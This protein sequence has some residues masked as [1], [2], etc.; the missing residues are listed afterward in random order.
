MTT[1]AAT[2][3][4][5]PIGDMEKRKV[6]EPDNKVDIVMGEFKAGK[7]RSSSGDKVTDPK[8]ALAIALSEQRRENEETPVKLEEKQDDPVSKLLP[9]REAVLRAIVN[10]GQDNFNSMEKD[11]IIEVPDV[12]LFKTGRY[13]GIETTKEDLRNKEKA[14]RELGDKHEPFLKLTHSDRDEHSDNEHLS[15]YPFSVGSI[16][17]NT[18]RVEGDSLGGLVKMFKWVA[19]LIAKGYLRSSS[20]EIKHNVTT[21]DGKFYSRV[22]D[23]LALL[24]SKREAQW[25]TLN[26]YHDSGAVLN[27]EKIIIYEFEENKMP[28]TNSTPTQE[29]LN[30]EEAAPEKE[31]KSENM[32]AE[33]KSENMEMDKMKEYMKDYMEK[34]MSEFMEKYMGKM[35][36]EEEAEEAEADMEKAEMYSE[37]NSDPVAKAKAELKAEYAEK[38]AEAEKR[39]KLLEAERI[40]ERRARVKQED[41][42]FVN[43]LV[44]EGKLAPAFAD[45]AFHLVN[46]ASEEVVAA[47]SE[48]GDDIKKSFKEQVKDFLSSMDKTMTYSE[49]EFAYADGDNDLRVTKDDLELYGG[50][51]KHAMA[52]KKAEREVHKYAEEKGISFEQ[53]IEEMYDLKIN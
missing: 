49:D 2:S 41:K 23:C 33:E 37:D 11:Y 22:F 36:S 40:K 7:L 8:Q 18:I 12:T 24:G 50:D 43:G 53:A 14:A 42:S 3:T 44:T 6:Y 27:C 10:I 20:A 26:A 32:E 17:P 1:R 9:I 51:A 29:K 45:R 4:E 16:P 47:Y 15:D 35:K 5:I 46:N 38:Y 48:S 52:Q 31:M 21:Q 34:Y 39:I 30:Y 25:E 19:E 13:N 28:K